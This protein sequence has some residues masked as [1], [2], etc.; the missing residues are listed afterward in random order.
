MIVGGEDILAKKVS[1]EIYYCVSND[2]NNNEKQSIWQTSKIRL[3]FAICEC[4]CII[5][6]QNSCNPILNIL[7]GC[8]Q[9]NVATNQW[10][11]YNLCD[12]IG[13]QTFMRFS[14]DIERV[15]L[16]VFFYSCFRF[17]CTIITNKLKYN[18]KKIKT[19]EASLNIF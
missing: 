1:D 13:Y 4:Q 2:I 18:K 10:L 12:V 8:N 17:L 7:G 11:Q 3:P 16:S 19:F 15:T 6:Q 9:N 14:I 5:T